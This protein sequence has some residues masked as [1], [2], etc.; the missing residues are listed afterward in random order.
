M[1]MEVNGSENVSIF[2][3]TVF[4]WS[5]YG[6]HIVSVSSSEGRNFRIEE[7]GKGVTNFTTAQSLFAI[8]LCLINVL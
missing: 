2:V 7:K 1:R 5:V 3:C 8:D 4:V 6:V